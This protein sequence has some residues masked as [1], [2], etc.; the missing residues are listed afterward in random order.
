[1]LLRGSAYGLLL[2]LIL[3]QPL[4]YLEP[5]KLQIFVIKRQLNM[6]IPRFYIEQSLQVGLRVDLP[7][8][9]HR[10][11]IQ[12]LRLK[13][14][15]V[16]I[17]FNGEGGEYLT[18]LAT[19]KK[20]HS[21]VNIISYDEVDRESPLEITLALAMIKADKMD[22]ALQKAVEMGVDTIQP[23]D[24]KRSVV[25]LKANRIDKKIAHWDGVMRAA[26]EQSGRTHIPQ[27]HVPTTLESWLQI[28]FSTLCVAML[29]EAHSDIASLN[30][31]ENKR[32]TL[33]VGPEGGFTDQEVGLLLSSNIKGIQFGPRILRAET[34]VIAGIALCQ[35]QWGDL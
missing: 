3:F 11:A 31:P 29:P 23:L 2:L 35:Q 4:K 8:D 15:D 17:L 26:C 10:H 6:R 22:F 16:L 28:P 33:L 32:M 1:M 12:V 20:R 19:V 9:I 27:L 13:V 30:S 25:R 24:T 5:P 21:S 7:K 34:A 18:T 14:N